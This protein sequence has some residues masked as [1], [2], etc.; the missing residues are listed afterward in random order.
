MKETDVTDAEWRI[1]LHR[2]SPWTESVAGDSAA[3]SDVNESGKDNADMAD[4][5]TTMDCGDQSTPEP[6][7]TRKDSPRL[8]PAPDSL[9]HSA[10]ELPTTL[11]N[12]SGPT[13]AP[14]NRDCAPSQA[15]QFESAHYDNLSYD[16]LHALC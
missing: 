4:V 3:A 1:S 13:S 7:E 10:R 16:Q 5:D 11:S 14:F 6:K 9:P 12:D 8:I 2:V 15:P